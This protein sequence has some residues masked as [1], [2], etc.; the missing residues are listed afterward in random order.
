MFGKKIKVME[1]KTNI[2]IIH[3]TYQCRHKKGDKGYIDGYVMAADNRPY[4]IVVC[5]E[6]LDFV[7]IWAMKV[8]AK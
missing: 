2:E 5:K 7:P 1:T 4:A 3:D 6:V 8:I